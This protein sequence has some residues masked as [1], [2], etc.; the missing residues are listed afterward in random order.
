VW[1]VTYQS[2]GWEGYLIQWWRRWATGGV[3]ACDRPHGRRYAARQAAK[4]TLFAAGNR[5][6]I[7]KKRLDGDFFPIKEGVGL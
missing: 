4:T 2:G 7:R 3:I 5:A 1:C 6:D